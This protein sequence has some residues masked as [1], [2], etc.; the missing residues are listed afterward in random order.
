MVHRELLIVSGI[1]YQVSGIRYQVSEFSHLNER[2][3][4]DVETQID[5][6]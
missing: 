4:D 1:G 6:E 3:T 5:R 2:S